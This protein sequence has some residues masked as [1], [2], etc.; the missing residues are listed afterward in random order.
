MKYADIK[1]G[2][3]YLAADDADWQARPYG[4]RKVQLASTQRVTRA[5]GRYRGNET[6]ELLDG[7]STSV[8]GVIPSATGNAVLVKVIAGA[9]AGEVIAV[10]L[11]QLRGEWETAKAESEQVVA[12]VEARKAREAE[13]RDTVATRLQAIR[14]DLVDLEIGLSADDASWKVSLQGSS[15]VSLPMDVLRQLLDAV[16]E[17]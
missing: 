4:H 2:T 5:S 10:P 15:S 12:A 1:P 7:S 13:L 16:N 3:D 8:W 17:G 9:R 14:Q 6:I 11:N